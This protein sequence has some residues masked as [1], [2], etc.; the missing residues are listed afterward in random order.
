[1]H[2]RYMVIIMR[3][4]ILDFP[5]PIPASVKKKIQTPCVTLMAVTYWQ[6][7]LHEK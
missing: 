7:I 3:R 5:I 6:N 1:M 4:E 2:K